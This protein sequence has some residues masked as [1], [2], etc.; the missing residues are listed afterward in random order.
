MIVDVHTHPSLTVWAEAS[1]KAAGGGEPRVN[2]VRIPSWSLDSAIEAMD[3]NDIAASILSDATGAV[4]AGPAGT[5]ELSRRMNEELASIVAARPQRFGAFAALPLLDID[6]TLRET[7]YA[8]DTL[9]FEGVCL[10][11]NVAGDYLGDPRFEPLFAELD[12][13]GAV[14]FMHPSTP[15]YFDTLRLPVNQAALEFVFDTTRTIA[16]LIYSGRRKRYPKFRMIAAHGGGT[17]PY[18]AHR[19]SIVPSIIP[20]GYGLSLTPEEIREQLQTFHFDLTAASQPEMVSALLALVP[21]GN[22][23]WGTDYPMMP[24]GTIAPAKAAFEASPL[25][26]EADR[27]AIYRGNALG[28]FPRLAARMDAIHA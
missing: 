10:Q 15:A 22:L 4:V 16:S 19:I 12:R 17:I 20:T 28:L 14:I 21:W 3:E 25:L 18:L 27:R 9:S 11:S 2:G 26:E 24:K 1:R 7:E 23:L 5:V 8:L 6:A 13:R